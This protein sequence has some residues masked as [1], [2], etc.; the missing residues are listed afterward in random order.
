[1]EKSETPSIPKRK[2]K[3]KKKIHNNL[4]TNWKKKIVFHSW[5]DYK[6]GDGF[7]SY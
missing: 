1:M 2:F 7:F 6:S 4:L 3:F 5:H